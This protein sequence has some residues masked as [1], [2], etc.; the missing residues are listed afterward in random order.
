MDA[1]PALPARQDLLAHARF[2][3]GLAGRLVADVT[4]AEDLAQDALLAGL[5]EPE[6]PRATRA[7][8]GGVVKN[9]FRMRARSAT[10]RRARE[11]TPR[12]AASSDPADV[13]AQVEVQRRLID[14]VL[15]LSEPYRS[16]IVY[17]YFHDLS[18]ADI[19]GLVGVPPATVRTRLA[20]AH[21]LLRER[22][23]R[24]HPSRATWT[25]ALLC[26][27]APETGAA[28]P[29]PLP[30]ALPMALRPM[31]VFGLSLVTTGAVGVWVGTRIAAPKETDTDSRTLAR[32]GAETPP[33]TGTPT[34]LRG[35]AADPAVGAGAGRKQATATPETPAA[36]APGA[37][38]VKPPAAADVVAPKNPLDDVDWRRWIPMLAK[39]GALELGAT[40]P[41]DLMKEVEEFLNVVTPKLK[42]RRWE[43][44]EDLFRMPDVASRFTVA[45]A[46][47]FG[48]KLTAAQQAALR[49]EL[50]KA[51]AEASAA[52]GD[53]LKF[54]RM[55]KVYEQI[56]Q[57][58]RVLEPV[59]GEENASAVAAFLPGLL[60]SDGWGTMALGNMTVP[61]LTDAA[62]QLFELR[63]TTEERERAD[64]SR[65]IRDWGERATNVQR[66]LVRQHGT[67]TVRAA[68]LAPTDDDERTAK[69]RTAA[70]FP[71]VR[72][73]VWAAFA[74][75]QAVTERALYA[76]WK[77]IPED[78]RRTFDAAEPALLLFW[79]P[80][81]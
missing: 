19:A 48:A 4:E 39:Y 76:I 52:G 28:V 25:R 50:E 56:A 65:V 73:R 6:R 3:R 32:A 30:G 72:A 37:A 55:A 46:E 20:R 1:A 74:R 51:I 81:A 11:S 27:A 57:A 49:S 15:E 75:E 79:N 53:L 23:D 54:E 64:V 78:R 77:Q 17:R 61:D 12:P 31:L 2:V 18:P 42:G 80:G 9:L 29:S 68:V 26:F 44:A 16:T 8:L 69:A 63:A 71:G 43:E 7:W 60:L 33:S 5:E 62:L 38:N 35:R 24:L 22:L 36:N 59:A 70:T 34:E 45:A 14:A 47:H 13:L 21:A 40:P 10:R 66:E 58:Y 41:D 67:P